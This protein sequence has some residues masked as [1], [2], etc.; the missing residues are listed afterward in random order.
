MNGIP[1]QMFAMVT[2]TSEWSALSH[3]TGSIPSS[4]MNR[5]ITP[6]SASNIHCQVVAETMIGSS[7][8]TRNNARS[9]VES[10]KFRWKKTASARP[11]VYWKNSETRTK[12]A[13][14]PRVGRN[15]GEDRTSR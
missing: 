9:N 15:C 2:E 6:E 13:V 3:Q 11:I 14:C 7:H 5:L 1:S 12:K 10:G 4:P 8:G